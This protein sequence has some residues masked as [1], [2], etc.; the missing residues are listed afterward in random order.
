MTTH[1]RLIDIYADGADLQGI[2]TLN[3]DPLISGI[4][5]NPTLM[6]KAG[7]QNY[8]VFAREMLSHVTEKP[9]SLEV[10]ADS[11]DDMHRQAETIAGW[12]SNVFVKIPVT[13]SLGESTAPIIKSLSTAGV[14]LNITAIMTASQV[15]NLLPSLGS[16]TPAI[17]SVFAGRIADTGRDPVP[18]LCA[19]RDLLQ[20]HPHLRLLWA[21]VREVL[22]ISQA[23]DAGC[24]IVTV[25]HDI[26]AKSRKMKNQDLDQLSLETVQMFLTD[27]QKA[28]YSL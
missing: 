15:N 16:P 28:G 6:R 11:L 13:N 26:L 19:V 4:T 23:Y 3:N 10:F 21:S 14:K 20:F 18:V 9:V 2:I 12:G 17:L 22:N 8:S 7:I 25:P 1:P 24:D 27:A 5:T